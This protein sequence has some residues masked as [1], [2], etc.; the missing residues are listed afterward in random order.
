MKSKG[1]RVRSSAEADEKCA[2]PHALKRG[3]LRRTQE[4]VKGRKYR[5]KPQERLNKRQETRQYVPLDE[6]DTSEFKEI[7]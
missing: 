2:Y 3:G 7:N 5:I 4:S 6:S 1:L